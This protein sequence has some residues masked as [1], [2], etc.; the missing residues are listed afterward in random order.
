[1]TRVYI[2]IHEAYFLDYV[3]RSQ[4]PG[5]FVVALIFVSQVKSPSG[6]VYLVGEPC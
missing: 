1:M 4:Y 6:S 5:F 2:Y 3:M